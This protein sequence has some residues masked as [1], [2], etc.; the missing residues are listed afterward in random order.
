MEHKVDPH[1]D[2]FGTSDSDWLDV[3]VGVVGLG[4]AGFACADAL[5]QRGAQ[6][7]IHDESNGA[8]QIERATILEILG[9]R[10]ELGTPPVAA[11]DCQLLIV[12][13]GVPPHAEVI[14][15]ALDR[16]IAV[17]GECAAPTPARCPDPAIEP[18]QASR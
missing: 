4:I 17:W 15:G 2:D 12:S 5:I 8:K 9:A 11:D 18:G 7:T 1:L 6:V 13:P 10:I 16:G 3:K 14:R